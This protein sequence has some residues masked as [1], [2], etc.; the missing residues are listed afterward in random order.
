[1]DHRRSPHNLYKDMW[2]ELAGMVVIDDMV[3][4]L[5]TPLT[6]AGDYATATLELAGRLERW[7]MDQSGFLWDNA[8]VGYFSN[9]AANMRL[10]TKACATL[11]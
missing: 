11:Q 3:S 10:W 2:N 1:V 7:S 8:L 6:P 5:E 9:V 4:L